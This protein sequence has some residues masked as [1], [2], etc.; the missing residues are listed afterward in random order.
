MVRK[1]ATFLLMAV[2]VLSSGIMQFGY[3]LCYQDGLHIFNHDCEQIQHKDSK[4]APANAKDCCKR[5]H[6][7]PAQKSLNLNADKTLVE[8]CC[9][10]EFFFFVNPLPEKL[11]TVVVPVPTPIELDCS[12]FIKNTITAPIAISTN[13]I[14]FKRKIPLLGINAHDYCRNLHVWLI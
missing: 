2:I 4:G 14:R 6:Q 13:H 12:A 5:S 8:D 1:F 10:H 9:T 3:H 7:V 11:I